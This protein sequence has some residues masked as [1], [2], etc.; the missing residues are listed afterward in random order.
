LSGTGGTF[1][2]LSDNE[3]T[4]FSRASGR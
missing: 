2:L 1:M 3:V 4:G